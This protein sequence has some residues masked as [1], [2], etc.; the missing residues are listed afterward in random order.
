MYNW[1]WMVL[2]LQHLVLKSKNSVWDKLHQQ[3]FTKNFGDKKAASRTTPSQN[4]N[5]WK[6]DPNSEQSSS[7]KVLWEIK[8]ALAKD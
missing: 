8:L 5:Q 2:N 3:R 1:A 4:A 7:K 6:A